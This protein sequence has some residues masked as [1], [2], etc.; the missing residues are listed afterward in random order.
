MYAK[1]I[2][3]YFV[4]ILITSQSEKIQDDLAHFFVEVYIINFDYHFVAHK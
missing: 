3:K 1:L 4:Q 2:L